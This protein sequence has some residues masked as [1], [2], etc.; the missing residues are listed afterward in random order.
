MSFAERLEFARTQRRDGPIPAVELAERAGVSTGALSYY[1]RGERTPR[2]DTASKL[3]AVLGVRPAWLL[4]GEAPMRAHALTVHNRALH[5]VDGLEEEWDQPEEP[6]SAK[7]AEAFYA[8]FYRYGGQRFPNLSTTV[9]IIFG[10]LLARAFN[11]FR[12]HGAAW[13]APAWRGKVAGE[14]LVSVHA[15]AQEEDSRADFDDQPWSTR[16]WLAALAKEMK[17]WEDG[18]LPNE[19]DRFLNEED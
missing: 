18:N 13:E 7:A 16:A 3:A 5:E 14:L 4:T 19:F 15:L 12:G 6:D 8:T 9:H 17:R 2:P 1:R 10:N 11:S